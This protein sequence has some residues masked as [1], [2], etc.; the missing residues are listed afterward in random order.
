MF[1]AI[2][3]QEKISNSVTETLKNWIKKPNNQK[4]NEI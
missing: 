1:A 2:V 4:K 3:S